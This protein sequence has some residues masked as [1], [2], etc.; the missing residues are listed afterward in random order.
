ME[1]SAFCCVGLV[2]PKSPENVGSVMRAAGCYGVDEVYYTGNRF[3][4]ARR[5]A[6][7]TKQM[8]E[9]I[10]LLGVDDLM[11]FV[12]QGCVPVVVDLIDGATPLPDYIHPKRAFYIFGPEDGTLDPAL[13]G[14]VKDVVY[15]PTQGCMNL[16]ASVNVILYDRLAKGYRQ[17]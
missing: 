9:K 2:N 16:A 11:A 17:P 15:V 14:A 13:Y 3:E 5:F 8:V 12:P 1:K 7:D 6:T 4:L 10:P